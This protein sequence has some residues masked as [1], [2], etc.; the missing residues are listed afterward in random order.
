MG[1]VWILVM[2]QGAVTSDVSACAYC[3]DMSRT[4]SIVDGQ[5]TGTDA[6]NFHAIGDVIRWEVAGADFRRRFGL[7]ETKDLLPTFLALAEVLDV[8]RWIEFLERWELEPVCQTAVERVCEEKYAHAGVVQVHGHALP[9]VERRRIPSTAILVSD[10]ASLAQT[11]KSVLAGITDHKRHETAVLS[12]EVQGDI[13]ALRTRWAAETNQLGLLDLKIKDE[14]RPSYLLA[15]VENGLSALAVA[16]G[17]SL[18]FTIERGDN[19]FVLPFTVTPSLVARVFAAMLAIRSDDSK[20]CN[21]P[22]CPKWFVP[23][24]ELRSYCE[25]HAT[26]EARQKMGNQRRK[27]RPKP[28]FRLPCSDC[29]EEFGTVDGRRA[30]AKNPRCDECRDA[31]TASSP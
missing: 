28:G 18:G 24:R 7:A 30:R 15:S 31:P 23:S 5:L 12:E 26:K 2:V 21:H 8:D 14:D 1:G 27:Q 29:G 20:P 16:G 22:G 11:A 4:I 6:T 19:P 10:L 25:D 17:Y 9:V 13:D 3:V